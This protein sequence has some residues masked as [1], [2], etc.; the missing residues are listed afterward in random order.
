M[1]QNIWK[2][3]I[4]SFKKDYQDAWDYKKLSVFMIILSVVW[5]NIHTTLLKTGGGITSDLV[6]LD[7]W[8]LGLL[9]TGQVAPMVTK[10]G[11]D[12]K[13]KEMDMNNKPS[14]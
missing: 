10:A 3:F 6:N 5:L 14:A 2:L 12:L 11:A 7:I 8:I 13:S 1:P 9:I 4:S